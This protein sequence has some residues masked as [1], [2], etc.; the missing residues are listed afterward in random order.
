MIT[1]KPGENTARL[2]LRKE[3]EKVEHPYAIQQMSN[4]QPCILIFALYSEMCS[5]PKSVQGI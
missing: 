1:V 2:W 5:S 3:R 4:T